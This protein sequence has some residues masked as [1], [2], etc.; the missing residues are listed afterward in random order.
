MANRIVGN[1]YILDTGSGNVPLPWPRDAKVMSIA[2]WGANTASIMQI[3][4]G[5]TSNVLIT[6]AGPINNAVGGTTIA[7]LGGV[8]FADTLTLPVL[9]AGTAW[10]Y[11]G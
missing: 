11:F 6:L 10:I 9:T 2:F 7:P 3:A 4:A 8:Y 5:D 1:V